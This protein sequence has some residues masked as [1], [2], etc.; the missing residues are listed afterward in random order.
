MFFLS[1]IIASSN[2]LAITDYYF[3]IIR[4][5]VYRNHKKDVVFKWVYINPVNSIESIYSVGGDGN[6]GFR[7]VSFGVFKDQT[8]WIKVKRDMLETYLKYHDTLYLDVNE[9]IIDSERAKMIK[10]LNSTKSPCLSTDDLEL[11]FGNLS[12]PQIVADTY[13]RP[14]LVYSF[15]SYTLSTGEVRNNFESSV[16]FPLINMDMTST[17]KPITI[18]CA[19]NHYY[20]IEFKRTPTGRLKKF[21]KPHINMD[22][23]RI[24]QQFPDIC[25]KV[26]YSK[27]F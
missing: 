12:C 22:H 2:A 26:D 27:L 24:R 6:C 3:I 13:E 7:A 21:E 25:N 14:V 17:E 4:I 10:R 1:F 20:Y 8:K 18:L 5:E 16:F 19:F 23:H 11:W 9:K 15:V